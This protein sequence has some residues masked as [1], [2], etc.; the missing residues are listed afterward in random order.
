MTRREMFRE[1]IARCKPKIANVPHDVLSDADKLKIIKDEMF[2]R[3]ERFSEKDIR[4]IRCIYR[5]LNK[6]GYW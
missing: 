1:V 6:K 3:P 2:V 4:K 5:F